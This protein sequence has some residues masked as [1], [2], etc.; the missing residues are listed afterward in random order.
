MF[1]HVWKLLLFLIL[2]LPFVS[3]QSTRSTPMPSILPLALKSPYFHAWTYNINVSSTWPGFWDGSILGWEGMVRIDNH[4]YQWLGSA[5][6][7]PDI[8]DTANLT[9]RQITPTK[10]IFTYIVGP[11]QLT[12]TFLS[13]IERSDPIKQSMP[14]TYVM[15]DLNFTDG[16]KHDVQVYMD[17][18]GEWL[19]PDTSDIIT[20][21]T[22][23][24][25][26]SSSSFHEIQRT[27]P[28]AFVEAQGGDRAQDMT[29]VIG[30]LL[31]D[32]V[33]VVAAGDRTSR[34]Q[35]ITS[36]NVTPATFTPPAQMGPPYWPVFT[37]VQ[38]LGNISSTSS[39]I[40]FALG[41][42]RNPSIL[43]TTTT[44]TGK[45]QNQIRAP[46]FAAS[47]GSTSDVMD[48]F[49]P[50]FWYAKLRA[51][52]VDS[53]IFNAT[54]N[55]SEPYKD[56][57][58]LAARQTMASTELTIANGT[59]GKWNMSDIKM[60]MK[61]VGV[62]SR[63]N[64]VE[65][66]YASF[67]FFLFINSTYAGQL[68]SPLL[69]V[70]DVSTNDQAFAARDLG[71]NYPRANGTSVK[72]DQPVEHTSSMLIMTYAHARMSGDGTL[73]SRHYLLLRKWAEYLVTSTM[74]P[75]DSSTVDGAT[76][77]NST[78][79]VIKGIIALKA[80]SEISNAVSLTDDANHYSKL[81]STFMDQWTSFT[82]TSSNDGHLPLSLG[83]GNSSSWALMYNLYADKLLN[84]SLIDEQIFQN[85]AQF[86]QSLLS[87]SP[88]GL[89]LDSTSGVA[90]VAWSLFT[91]ATISNTTIRNNLIS[92][93]HDQFFKQQ[94]N[95]RRPF[96]VNY[97]IDGS[98]MQGD[99]DASPAV[100]AIFAPL[101]LS[102]T[103][104]QSI[105]V[106]PFTPPTPTPTISEKHRSIAGPVAGGVVGGIALLL[107][108]TLGV[109]CL[110]RRAQTDAPY[111]EAFTTKPKIITY[112]DLTLA[113]EGSTSPPQ[114]EQ[115]EGSL[116]PRPPGVSE[117]T[118]YVLAPNQSLVINATSA[119]P[120][121]S[122]SE[123]IGTSGGIGAR[124]NP[125][126]QV[127]ATE[128]QGL[129]SEVEILRQF[130][131]QLQEERIEAPPSYVTT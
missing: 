127:S 90:S 128:V 114:M 40:V 107:L 36:G 16:L 44:S 50:E 69:E 25:G 1:I 77:A 87:Q 55:I 117:K 101:A 97:N 67:P 19:T 18:S 54:G 85:Q 52:D 30:A 26:T 113:S 2:L 45:T 91:A 24:V 22:H 32:H 62:S 39:P 33:S 28:Q 21:S 60:F 73:I 112:E 96:P 106:P 23:S 38:D 74:S 46:L 89:P 102:L 86:Y 8:I 64:P 29:A 56:L 4:A 79:L 84:T 105:T 34:G 11:A 15:L 42:Y 63:V 41:V 98:D 103:P 58:S 80:M 75:P 82:Q 70:Q 48:A 7:F 78:N 65:K 20:W 51:D 10:T 72:H 71:Q 120:D 43:L 119:S 110:R 111:V 124:S 118:G 129:R 83:G 47:L 108:A 94:A 95:D 88:G 68:L 76:Y 109:F 99:G 122:E 35:F 92:S 116:S 6:I 31:T 37:V 93:V 17:I 14:L 66:I 61:D 12:A 13:P 121:T 126:N 3:S 5:N 9:D 100:G 130:M 115:G 27:M 59:D 131:Q 125:E 104:A 57:L 49:L 81:A 123:R 53:L